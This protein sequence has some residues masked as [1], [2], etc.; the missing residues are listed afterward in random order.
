MVERVE[1]Y[2][3]RHSQLPFSLI[4]QVNN[5]QLKVCNYVRKNLA[6]DQ[7]YFL[8]RKGIFDC[9]LHWYLK[10][11]SHGIVFVGLK[12]LGTLVNLDW[13][14]QTFNVQTFPPSILIFWVALFI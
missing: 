13:V 3:N 9:K 10:L 11:Y 8:R 2:F 12:T 6:S 14:V 1:D 4:F 5:L 7:L